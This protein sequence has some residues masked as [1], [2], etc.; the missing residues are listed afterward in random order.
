MVAIIL[1]FDQ[2]FLV[3]AKLDDFPIYFWKP[4][5]Q[6]DDQK[7]TV[8]KFMPCGPDKIIFLFGSAEKGFEVNMISGKFYFINREIR[9]EIKIRDISIL[10]S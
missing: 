4:S 8:F 2:H 9:Y 6:I 3:N 1:I 10:W 5:Y 7:S